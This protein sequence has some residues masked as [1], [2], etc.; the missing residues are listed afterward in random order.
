MRLASAIKVRVTIWQDTSRRATLHDLR[1]R[2]RG[3]KM[4]LP[5]AWWRIEGWPTADEWQAFGSV[6]T[7][8]VA[9]VAAGFAWW[10]IKQARDLSRE[11]A[12]PYVAAY[13]DHSKEVD[14]SMMFFV[15]KNF[16]STAAH[17]VRV[18]VD[19]PMER[20]WGKTAEPE[21]INVPATL[22]MLVPG[23]EWTTL[24]DW[25]PHRILAELKDV[26]TVTI[27]YKDSHGNE[28][29]QAVSSIDWTHHGI[30]RKLGVRTTH[31]IGKSVQDINVTLRKWSE[32]ASG[33]LSVLVRDG[34]AKDERERER[35][36]QGLREHETI[37]REEEVETTHDLTD[38]EASAASTGSFVD[39]DE[40]N[41]GPPGH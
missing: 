16:G 28:M 11:Q 30:T 2:P 13:L 12:Q 29:A 15:I 6:G 9:V 4:V 1:D 37:H 23:Q 32:G 18:S 8:V 26:Y 25:L 24:F 10:Q 33:P 14:P 19:P 34:S 22:P 7:L 31:H 41:T 5:A 39:P 40:P 3:G 35:F 27:K 36:A 38:S 17:D 21:P 20:A